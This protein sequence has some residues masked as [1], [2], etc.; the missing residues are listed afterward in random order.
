MSV[1]EEQLVV[2]VNEYID[3]DG[4]YVKEYI[5]VVPLGRG[6][7]FSNANCCQPKTKLYFTI[8]ERTPKRMII[9]FDIANTA[10]LLPHQN[11]GIPSKIR[12]LSKRSNG[13]W[14]PI[15]HGK[16]LRYDY[17]QFEKEIINIS[18]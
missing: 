17:T 6:F 1:M 13:V 10:Y 9:E 14:I 11:Q 4:Y 7:L 2:K 15:H 16:Y 8:L 3:S 18:S 5:N 12:I